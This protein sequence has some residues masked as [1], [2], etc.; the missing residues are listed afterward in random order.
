MPDQFAPYIPEFITVHLGPPKSDA[1]N[2]TVSFPDYIKNVASSEIYPTWPESALRANIL[3][4]ISFALNR[5]YTEW[6][7]SQGYDFD[8]TNSTAYDQ[9]F[10]EGRDVFDNISNIVDEIFN[11]YVVRSGNVEP[12]FTQYCDGVRVTD[13]GGLLQV[14]SVELANRGF[15][16][17]EILKYYYGDNIGIVENAPV[18]IPAPSYPGQP[19]RRNDQ[20]NDVL[21]MQIRLNRISRNYPLIP[22][23]SP[24]DGIFSPGTEDS[25]RVF[26][27]I[28]NLPET[29]VVDNA[30]WNRINYI[31]VSVK[32]LAELGSEGIAISE[33]DQQFPGSLQLG[34]SG[35]GVRVLQFLLAVISN[36]YESVPPLEINSTFDDATQAAVIAFQRAAGI[37]PD[38]IVGAETWG[39]LQSAYRSIIE[40]IPIVEGAYI[41]FPGE[42]LS[43]GSRGQYVTILQQYLSYISQ[44]LPEIPSVAV[45]GIFG[46]QTEA[47][48]KVFQRLYGL[49]ENGVVGTLTWNDI[50]ALYS[51]LRFG[52]ASQPG[53]FPGLTIAEQQ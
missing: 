35:R 28:F 26:Q 12:L 53:Q 29:G 38:G 52:S 47:A 22:K 31:Y 6:Y 18:R 19:L 43:R 21:L 16:P 50:A 39:A 14:G 44:T 30:T 20:G 8:I 46:P 9:S 45:D 34:S 33:F 17:Y 36:F 1:P 27:R 51:D 3:A 42:L 40:S 11:S 32:R 4:Q 10:V 15:T 49:P 5:I 41:P 25:V 23:I 7:R 37:T 2:V 48:V 24:V 13:C